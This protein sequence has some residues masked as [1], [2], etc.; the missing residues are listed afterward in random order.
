MSDKRNPKKFKSRESRSKRFSDHSRRRS[1]SGTLIKARII[2]YKPGKE[3]GLLMLLEGSSK[4]KQIIFNNSTFDKSIEHYIYPNQ[5]V[6]VKCEAQENQLTITE[7]VYKP[8]YRGVKGDKEGDES[9][10]KPQEKRSKPRG[11]KPKDLSK[12]KD[13]SRP[14]IKKP[15]DQ[16]STPTKQKRK[17]KKTPEIPDTNLSSSVSDLSSALNS[18]DSSIDESLTKGKDNSDIDAKNN[19]I[20]KTENNLNP[21]EDL[22]LDALVK[23]LKQDS[24]QIQEEEILESSTQLDSDI[25]NDIDDLSN[26][27]KEPENK[28]V[29][30]STVNDKEEVVSKSKKI[31]E[32]EDINDLLNSTKDVNLTE[33]DSILANSDDSN[34]DD[35]D[36]LVSALASSG[37]IDSE[38][39]KQFQT[40]Q[41]PSSQTEEVEEAEEDN[42]SEYQ[43]GFKDQSSTIFKPKQTPSKPEQEDP[44]VTERKTLKE[45]LAM[46]EQEETLL[47]KLVFQAEEEIDEDEEYIYEDTNEIQVDE[48]EDNELEEEKDESEEEKNES[49][50]EEGDA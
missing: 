24:T 34:L 19:E 41:Q 40:M 43:G 14:K 9:K 21:D 10:S 30:D 50:K 48:E 36:D 4:F 35:L 25:P 37:D 49:E 39:L 7:I 45:E 33:M 22:D 44:P 17:S 5:V 32:T 18:L 15:T 2:Q 29:S 42:D 23:G 13:V 31:P 27:V 46:E 1:S 8:Q 38:A 16:I 12:P 20:N 28:I 11:S 3:S 26:M 6:N 47:E